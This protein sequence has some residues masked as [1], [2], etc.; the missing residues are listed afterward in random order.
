MCSMLPQCRH[1][2]IV[3]LLLGTVGTVT[4]NPSWAARI[5]VERWCLPALQQHLEECVEQ[6]QQL[7]A[8]DEHLLQN[9]ALKECIVNEL[10]AR[11]ITLA[12]AVDQFSRLMSPRDYEILR[13]VGQGHSDQERIARSVLAYVPPRVDDA[14]ERKLLMQQLEAELSALLHGSVAHCCR[15]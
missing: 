10:I 7:E 15:P 12:E 4:M 5:G 3:T 13:Y 6:R 8:Y 1:A 11:R 14:A 9:I 2:L